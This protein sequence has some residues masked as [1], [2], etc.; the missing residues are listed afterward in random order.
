MTAIEMSMKEHGISRLHANL[1]M[2][3]KNM[4]FSDFAGNRA[5]IGF[6]SIED[7]VLI[8]SLS[9]SPS[10]KWVRRIR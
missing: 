2:A 4:L 7:R 9:I 5:K 6:L 3:L 10:A 1:L 8:E